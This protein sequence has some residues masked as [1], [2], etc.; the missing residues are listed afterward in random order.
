[1]RIHDIDKLDY[2]HPASTAGDSIR[3]RRGKEGEEREKE[4]RGERNM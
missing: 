1:M 2:L 3:K 4:K